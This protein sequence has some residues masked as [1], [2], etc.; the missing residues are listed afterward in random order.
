MRCAISLSHDLKTGVAGL[1]CGRARMSARGSA[2]AFGS[3]KLFLQALDCLL[4]EQ[5]LQTGGVECGIRRLPCL[6]WKVYFSRSRR[7]RCLKRRNDHGHS[8]SCD[9]EQTQE[10]PSLERPILVSQPRMRLLHLQQTH[11][12]SSDRRQFIMQQAVPFNAQ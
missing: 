6:Q 5:H 3:F 7:P 9:I 2:E 12:A 4:H 1:A 8:A 10:G 11:Q